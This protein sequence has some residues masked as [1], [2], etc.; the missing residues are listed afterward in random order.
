M[1]RYKVLLPCHACVLI[2]IWP[3][4][5]HA[6]LVKALGQWDAIQ[7]S[8]EDVWDGHL[9]GRFAMYVRANGAA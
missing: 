9:D 3:F 7:T 2:L 4:D 8:F 1:C 5:N 6:M